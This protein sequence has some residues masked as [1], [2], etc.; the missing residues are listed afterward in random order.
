MAPIAQTENEQDFLEYDWSFWGRPK[1]LRC[2]EDDWKFLAYVTGR[3]FGKTLTGAQWVR[4]RCENFPNQRIML[5][6]PTLMD[7]RETMIE[8]ESGILQACPPWA[9]PVY[10]P[11]RLLLIWPNGSMAKGFGA[12]KPA[13]LRG[14]NIT[15]AWGDEFAAW[16]KPESF[17]NLRM[18]LRK[19]RPQCLLTTTPKVVP[20]VLDLFERAKVRCP[21][22]KEKTPPLIRVCQ[23]CKGEIPKLRN[24]IWQIIKGSTYENL[25]NMAKDFLDMFEGLQGTRYGR[26]ELD[27]DL[28][29]D[30]EGALWSQ[31]MIDAHRVTVLPSLVKKMAF[32]D[33]SASNTKD[34]DETGIVVLGQA[35]NKHL[36][37]LGDYSVKGGDPKHWLPQLAKAKREHGLTTV[38]Y[39]R[40]QGGLTMGHTIR[41]AGQGWT[42]VLDVYSTASK[43]IRAE[44]AI[45]LY[46]QGLI[47]HYGTATP[48]L[49]HQMT[50]TVLGEQNQAD[51]R[52]DALVI[53]IHFLMPGAIALKGL[54]RPEGW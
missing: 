50:T 43:R 4:W 37:V 15:G 9:Q 20:A 38:V 22:C 30:V 19:G 33:S 25:Q 54:K 46:Q 51:D 26:Q 39:E 3:G 13:R 18:C 2:F 14:P 17:K 34:S 10:K 11:S 16:E 31:G 24:R 48:K 42:H 47:H 12:E 41:N 5:V 8:G 40:N 44:P 53:G 52:I 23:N 1:Q 45:P 35:A 7:A 32:V 28:L 36:Y 49:E 21:L 27:G 29:E 6:G